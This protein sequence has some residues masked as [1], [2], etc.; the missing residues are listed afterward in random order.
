MSM[1]RYLALVRHGQSQYNAD[2]RFTGWR[3]PALT[4]RGLAEASAVAVR[5]RNIG[6]PI[7]W[8][9]CSA[10]IRTRETAERVAYDLGRPN[11]PITSDA[12]LDER[13]YGE[14][15]GLNKDQACAHWGE[16]QV[17]RWRR[18]YDEA[19]PGGESLRDTAARVLPFYLQRIL[20]AVMRNDASLIVAH[21]N[22]L[23]AL[24][25]VL[26]QLSPEAIISTE[27]ATGELLVYELQPDTTVLNK[28]RFTS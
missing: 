26:D 9:F 5:L 19:P 22:S 25:M 8:I 12:A 18:S 3:D 28:R 7:D 13:D 16:S 27:I 24:V 4:A 2:N 10:L 23:R 11:L 1:G 21:G 6:L 17:Q 14:L 15:T 20:P